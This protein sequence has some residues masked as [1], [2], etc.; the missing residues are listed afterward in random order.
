MKLLRRLM[1][2][3]EGQDIIEYA[4]LICLVALVVAAAFPPITSAISGAFTR[5]STCLNGGACVPQ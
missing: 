1:V 3:T 2:E 4:L 5:A